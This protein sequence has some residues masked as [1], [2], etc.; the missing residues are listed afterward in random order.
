LCDFYDPLTGRKRT[1]SLGKWQSPESRREHARICAEAA[2][3]RP[4]TRSGITVAE[5]LLAFLEHAE[6]HY[7]RAD[8]TSTDELNNCKQTMRVVRE[9]YGHTHAAAFGPLALKAVRQRMIEK[10][11]IR[12]ALPEGSA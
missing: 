12:M 11:S 1:L 10:G 7:R 2:V 8:G 9:L 6:T 3:G 4:A 5:L